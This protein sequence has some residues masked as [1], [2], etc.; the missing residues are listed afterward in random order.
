LARR[1]CEVLMIRLLLLLVT[2]AF[3]GSCSALEIRRIADCAGVV[4]RMRG[5][6]HDGDYARFRS[7]FR[8][9][10]TIIGIDLSSYGGDLEEGMRIANLTFQKRLI[11]YVTE[12][13]DSVCA[14]VFFAAAKRYVSPT[15]KIGVHSAANYRDIEDLGSM[16]LTLTLARKAAKLG[17][18]E[19]AIGKM[20]TTRPSSITYLDEAELAALAAMVGSPFHYRPPVRTS[21][22]IPEGGQICSG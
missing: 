17:A 5:D 2:L 18:S 3:A 16:R 8:K 9:N 19:S 14:F 20:V 21:V 13:C 6:F 4:L 15:A 7:H 22:D 10:G 1:D 12:E 11:V